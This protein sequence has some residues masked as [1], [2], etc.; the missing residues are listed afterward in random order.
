MWKNLCNLR[1]K[2]GD[3]MT[4]HVNSFNTL[5]IHL[6]S[7]DIYIFYEGKCIILLFSLT[8]SWDSLVISIGSIIQLL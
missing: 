5:V 3:S 8:Y 4:E 6:L 2:D 7:F 1:M